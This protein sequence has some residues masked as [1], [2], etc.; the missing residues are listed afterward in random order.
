MGAKAAETIWVYIVSFTGRFF[1][2]AQKFVILMPW[3]KKVDL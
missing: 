1:L 3:K 2:L